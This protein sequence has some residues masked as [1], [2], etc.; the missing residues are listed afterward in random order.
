MDRKTYNEALDLLKQIQGKMEEAV[1]A[2]AKQKKE[3]EPE[4]RVLCQECSPYKSEHLLNRLLIHPEKDG[5]TIFEY[6]SERV[7]LSSTE[8]IVKEHYMYWTKTDIA[9]RITR[10]L[11]SIQSLCYFLLQDSDFVVNLNLKTKQFVKCR[12]SLDNI[13]NGYI[14]NQE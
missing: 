1:D 13:V 10:N 9:Q 11:D 7:D 4:V 12:Y 8:E 2:I 6:V 14:K 3:E 5:Y